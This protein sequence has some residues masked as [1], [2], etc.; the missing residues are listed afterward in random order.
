MKSKIAHSYKGYDMAK[1]MSFDIANHTYE[2]KTSLIKSIASAILVKKIKFPNRNKNKLLFSMGPYGGRNDY[3]EI[4]KYARSDVSSDFIDLFHA[5]FGMWLSIANFYNCLTLVFQSALPVKLTM[6]LSLALKLCHYRNTIDY[7]EKQDIALAYTK[8]CSFCSAHAYEAIL[9]EYFRKRDKATYTLQHGFY[10]LYKKPPIDMIMYENMISDK[11]L[12]WG[13]FTRHEFIKFGIQPERIK[14][15][16]YPRSTKPLK[17]YKVQSDKLHILL[18]CARKKFDENNRTIMRLC[19]DFVQ[20][21]HG[22]VHITVKAHP[23][24]DQKKYKQLSISHGFDYAEDQTIRELI[25][26][27][28]YDFAITYNSTAYLDCYVNNLVALHFQDS[29]R[30]NDAEVLND[31]FSNAGE[32]IS[33]IEYFVP[34]TNQIETWDEVATQL[35]YLIGYGENRYAEYFNE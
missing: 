33:K 22:K 15:A 32:L 14:V 31:R 18:L 4:L 23:S 13:E 6:K 27:G 9:D 25:S 12:C 19:L 20:K 17:P 8:Y 5:K 3:Y 11:L 35:S 30:E 16:G 28:I 10:F 26:S 1:I 21:Y 7:M 34:K 29:N 24:L 2:N